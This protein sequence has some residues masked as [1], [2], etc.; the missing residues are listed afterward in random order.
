MEWPMKLKD[1]YSS[2]LLVT[3]CMLLSLGV[4]NW[5][6][7]AVQ[8]AKYQEIMENTA[9][10]GLENTYLSFQELD[11]Q[12]NAEVLRRINQARERYNA[13][14]V[15]IDFYYVVLTGGRLLFCLGLLVSFFALIRIIRRDTLTK[16]DR[17]STQSMGDV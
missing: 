7:G 6:V 16:M 17:L 5:M 8:A 1:M 9:R 14:R 3:G 10:T 11:Y 15:K 13:A 4:G 2:Y 12:K